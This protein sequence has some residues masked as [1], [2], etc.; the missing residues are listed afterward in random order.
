MFTAVEMEKI[1][2]IS[3]V[4]YCKTYANMLRFA[5]KMKSFKSLSQAVLL[6]IFSKIP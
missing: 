6:L 2:D 3:I 5:I 4:T 1:T